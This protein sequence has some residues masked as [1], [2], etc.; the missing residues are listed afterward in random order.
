MTDLDKGNSL[1]WETR[2][3]K[4]THPLQTMRTT[5]VPRKMETLRGLRVWRVQET[6]QLLLA[7]AYPYQRPQSK[8][9]AP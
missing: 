5:L 7:N 9:A 8:V 3:L 4:D 6:T 1:F 2:T